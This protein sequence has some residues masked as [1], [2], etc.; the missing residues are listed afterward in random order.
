LRPV[1]IVALVCLAACSWL[2]RVHRV[3]VQQGNVLSQEMVDKLKPG[4][5]RRQVAFVMGEPV[6]KDPFDPDRWDYVYSIRVPNVGTQVTHVSL[7]FEND[8]LTTIA[9]DLMPGGA[10]QTP[11]AETPEEQADAA[12]R[13]SAVP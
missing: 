11:R 6:L 4:M 13:S 8:L 10:A 3:T 5:T 7:L 9:G 1:L 12:A 2:P